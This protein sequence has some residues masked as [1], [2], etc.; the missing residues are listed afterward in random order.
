MNKGKSGLAF[1]IHHDVLIEW[2][3]D[4]DG[5]VR[6]IRVNK[7]LGEQ[8][9]RLKLFKLIPV[10]KL[11]EAYNKAREAYT[12]AWEAY[13]KAGEAYDEAREAWNEAREAYTKAWKALNKAWEAYAKAWEAYAP[14]LEKLHQELCPDCP[15]DNEKQTI[16]TRK[17]ANGNWY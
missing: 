2:C 15:W 1:H 5:R 16:F 17:D 12:K 8:E 10:N 7:P 14:I 4:Y 9:L 3:S 11:P 6:S 13:N